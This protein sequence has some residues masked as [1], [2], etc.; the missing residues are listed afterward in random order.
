MS[1]LDQAAA[2]LRA[3]LEGE[4][5]VVITVTDPDGNIATLRG[6]QT[7][8]GQ[9]IDPETGV[10]VAGRKASVALSIAALTE[11]GLGEPRN[12]ADRDRK[13][14][15]VVFTAPT[16]ALQTFKVSEALP[17]KQGCIVCM[18]EAYKP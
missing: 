10:A 18:L 5:A 12:I 1:L 15:I 13:P 4:F 16:G 11:A 14:W 17:D 8:I 3:I 9:S 7:D 2:D 6:L